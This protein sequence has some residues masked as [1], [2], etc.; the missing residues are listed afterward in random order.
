MNLEI[1]NRLVEY[2]KR[3]GY[4]Q[5]ELAD[6]LGISRQ[7]VS[8]WE[9]VE[10]SPDTDNLIALANLYGVSLDELI[11]GKKDPEPEIK[12]EEPKTETTEPEQEVADDCIH[13]GGGKGV[14]LDS[15]DGSYVHID[16]DGIH[17]RNRH[18]HER[19]YT[20]KDIE[21]KVKDKVG[22]PVGIAYSICGTLAL[23]AFFA[24]GFFHFQ[25]PLFNGT[26]WTLTEPKFG[27][28]FSWIFFLMVPIIPSIMAAVR[29]KRW[30][31]FNMPALCLV[32]FLSAGM[33]YGVWHPMWIAFLMI[34]L[35]Y[36]IFGPIDSYI[37]KNDPKDCCHHI[38]CCSDKDDDDDDDDEEDDD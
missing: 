4:S 38:G 17:T 31:A 25:F 11:N 12:N 7:A 22:G 20:E 32:V 24:V 26:T 28:T 13:I 6:K 21:H 2:R 35:Y 15:K 16:N 8:K 14:R 27:F 9:R 5:E 23:V 10:A 29:K 18:G 37:H 33:I 3:A 1:A 30:C 34:P 19:H 36:T